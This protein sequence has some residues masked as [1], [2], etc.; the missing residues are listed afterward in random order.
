MKKVFG[1]LV[2]AL[3]SSATYAAGFRVALQS[4]KQQG[5]GHIG[6]GLNVGPSNIFFNP[7]ALALQDKGG[8]DVGGSAVLAS[9][10]YNL[11]GTTITHDLEDNVGTPV[12]LYGSFKLNDRL[13]GGLGVYTPYGNKVEWPED[14]TGQFVSELVDLKSFF[15]QPTLSYQ[16]DEKLGIGAG[17]IYALGT[18]TLERGIPAPTPTS[19]DATLESDG[20]A[21]GIGFNAGVFYQPTEELSF[22]FNYRSKVEVDAEDGLVSTSFPANT[23]PAITSLFQATRF[24]ATLPLPTEMAL[25]A[26]WQVSDNLP[27]VE[28]SANSLN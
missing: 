13:A 7:G 21:S 19:N 22:G 2:F 5:M 10:Q 1:L 27:C 11:P 4:T 3:L 17:L 25:G 15:I 23:N 24:D 6:A 8:I 18:V 28:L 14:W 9:N 12:F 20:A 26:G 16:L